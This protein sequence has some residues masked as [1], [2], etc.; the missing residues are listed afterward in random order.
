LNN[1][2]INIHVSH[3]YT[4]LFVISFGFENKINFCKIFSF[5]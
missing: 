2:Q 1:R 3:I 4:Y 5:K